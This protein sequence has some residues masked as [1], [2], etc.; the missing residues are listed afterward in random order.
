MREIIKSI[1]VWVYMKK[2]YYHK[3]KNEKANINRKKNLYCKTV[4]STVQENRIKEYFVNNYGKNYSN[5]WHRLY[6]SYTGKYD[7]KYFPEILYSTKLEKNL[8]PNEMATFLEDKSLVELLYK[9]VKNLVLPKTYILNCSGIFYDQHRKVISYA[10]ALKK[11]TSTKEVVF[12]KT[13][14]SSSG[15]SIR[16]C[17]F[18]DGIDIKTG[19]SIQKIFDIYSENFIVQECIKNCSELRNLH[20]ASINTFRVMT[21]IVEDKIYHS[22]IV[23]RIGTGRNRVDNAHAGGLFIG[24][25]DNGRLLK[26]AFTECGKVYNFHPDTNIVFSGYYIPKVKEMIKIAYACHENTPHLKMISWDFTV[27]NNN[28]IVLIETNTT[29]QSIW[30]SQIS[31]GCGVFGKNTEKMYKLISEKKL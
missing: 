20:P 10:D 5:K 26:K 23:L 21:Y 3:L 25:T 11:I 6:Q 22:P 1:I 29:G 16:I 27:N 8:N 15:R 9:N 19:D 12:K 30:L 28:D 24:V 4:F 31:H 13:I 17:Q 2:D 14:N 7:E 18:S